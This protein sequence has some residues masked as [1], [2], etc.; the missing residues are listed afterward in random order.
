[1]PEQNAPIN[2]ALVGFGTGGKLFHAPI[3]SC[4]Q[5]INLTAIVTGNPAR[6]SQAQ[7]YQEAVI[8]ESLD[9]L[10]AERSDIDLIVLTTP[11]STHHKLA[12]QALQAGINVVVDKPFAVT[13]LEADEMLKVASE[14]NKIICPYQ[15]R[16]FDS[17]F[18]TLKKVIK[19]G[20]VGKI[21]RLESRIERYRRLP[22]AGGWR[23]TTSAQD[24]GGVL[25]DLGSH[26]IDQVVHLFGAPQRL[27]YAR[28]EQ[29]RGLGTSDD[30]TLILDYNDFCV[31]IHASMICASG[32]PRFRLL[33]LDGAY[34]KE[35]GDIQ[36][37][38]LR[39]GLSP[40]STDFGKEPQSSYGKLFRQDSSEAVIS[41]QGNWLAYYQQIAQ[42]IKGEAPPPVSKSEI[43]TTIKIIEQALAMQQLM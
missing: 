23:E 14:Q 29:M 31:H 19:E 9:K 26:L 27:S 43:L 7:K 5:N 13:T 11:N 33:G 20:A 10:L 1:M 17:D 28:L 37:D 30:A 25:Y 39:A 4:A 2:A 21:M 6:Q 36:E 34:L 35:L 38:Q 24:G 16:R 12:I 42:A 8:Y 15:N 40:T 41:E 3:I 18:L 22:K 32:G